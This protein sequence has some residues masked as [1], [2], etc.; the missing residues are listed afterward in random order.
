M[1]VGAITLVVYIFK[2]AL[3]LNEPDLEEGGA[4]NLPSSDS[5]KLSGGADLGCPFARNVRDPLGD[6]WSEGEWARSAT[7]PESRSLPCISNFYP[8]TIAIPL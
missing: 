7:G 6:G 3:G 8:R 1:L 5:L 2:D 4:E